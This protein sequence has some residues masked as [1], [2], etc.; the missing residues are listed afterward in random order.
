MK[1]GSK[2][3]TRKETRGAGTMKKASYIGAGVAAVVG[4]IGLVTVLRMSDITLTLEENPPV[5]LPSPS[6]LAALPRTPVPTAK[7]APAAAANAVPT[8][9]P[10]TAAPAAAAVAAQPEPPSLVMPAE[11][12]VI[13]PFSADQLVKSKTM[14]DWRVHS[15][16][17]I[18]AAAG[19]EVKAAADGV[20][21]RAYQDPQMGYTIILAH[22]GE[23]KTVYQNLASVEMVK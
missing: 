19:A 10:E 7:P 4:L 3:N 6:P 2:K 17:D 5:T 1:K 9:A 18:R 22:D 20:V 23:F 11:G 13:T 21:E 14:G 12:E 15:G 8:A 16:I